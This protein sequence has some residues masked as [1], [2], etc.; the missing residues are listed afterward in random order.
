MIPSSDAS[1]HTND[2]FQQVW[3]DPQSACAIYVNEQYGVLVIPD[4]KPVVALGHVL[5]IA[6]EAI[7]FEDLPVLRKHQLLEAGDIIRQRIAE[8]FKPA[9]KIGQCIWGNQIP[10][11]HIH[12][13]PRNNPEDGRGFFDEQRAWAAAEQ[14]QETRRRLLDVDTLPG[15]ET[16]EQEMQRR[17]AAIRVAAG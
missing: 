3:S 4:K 14:L 10:T 1:P 17:L 11:A 12:Y 15:H 5:V 16:L 6:R 13:F 7:P 2:V 9:R 8:A